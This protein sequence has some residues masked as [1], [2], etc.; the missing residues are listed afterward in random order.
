[1]TRPITPQTNLEN[2]KKEAK[3]WLKVLRAGD[4]E[5][6]ERFAQTYPKAPA[7]PGLRDVQ[8][9]LARVYGFENWKSLKQALEKRSVP[10]NEAPRSP[11]QL[12]ALFL[13]Y[14]CPD[15]HVRGRPAHHMAIHAAK[16]LLD[17][18]PEIARSNLYTAIVCGEIDEVE[19]I[20]R[21]QP[22]LVRMKS[23]DT[24]ADR[25]DV[26]GSGDLFKNIGAKGWE[27]LSYLCFARLD[28]SKT[29]DNA[30]AIARLLLDHGADPNVYFMAGDSRYTPLTGV[31]GEG[32]EDRP[33]HPRRDE[34]ARLLLE[35]GAEPYDGQVIYNIHFHGNVLWYLKLMYEFSLKAGRKADWDDPEWHMLDQGNYGSGARWHL[36][37]AIDHND[38][39]LAE[40]CL[41]HGATPNAATPQGRPRKQHPLY[42]Q[43]VRLG[44]TE[45]ATL[46]ERHGATRVTIATDDEDALLAACFRRDRANAER[47]LQA[48]PEYLQSHVA[49]HSAAQQDRADVVEFVL[50]LGVS[51]NVQDEGQG[52][53]TALHVAAYA[54]SESVVDML[55]RRGAKIDPVDSVH[56]ATPLWFAMWAQR[57]RIITL[58]ARYSRDVW[59]LNF[60]GH[61]E[62][63]REVLRAEPRFA[64]MSG[65][66]TPLF[67]LPED[68]QQSV[69]IVEMFLALG[70]D[71]RFRR[72]ED[73]LT[74]SDVAR[75]R[76]LDAAADRL[77]AAERHTPQHPPI[78]TS[79][80]V[81]NYERLAVAMVKAYADADPESL[82]QIRA[83]YGR[84]FTVDDLRAIVWR[85]MYK[86]RQASG[87]AEAF[88]LAEAQELIAR[89][90]GYPNWSELI[91][92]V[93]TGT[94]APGSVYAFDPKENRI[95]PRRILH[96]NEWDAIIAVMQERR[97][98]ALDAAGFVTDEA[99]ERIADLEFVTSLNL[100]GSRGLSDDGLRQ[101]ARMPQLE[102]LNLS[103]YPGGKLTDKGLEVLRHLPNLKR[104][105]MT[106]QKGISDAGPA[107]LKYCDQLESVNL[108]GTR[109]G[110][111][112]IEAL[113][114]KK[115][116]RHFSS[117]G[118]ATDE[119]LALLHDFP[120]F[121][122]WQ[123]DEPAD[124]SGS[125]AEPTKLLIDGPFTDRGLA[126]L[127]GLEGIF[128]LD[129]FWHVTGITTD[130]FASLAGMTHLGSLGCDG[131]L[132][133]DTSMRHIAA[134]PRL[135]RL[136]AQ[137]SIAGDDGFLALSA[138][139]TLE[140]FWGRECPNF[141][142]RG[143]VAFSR[144]PA[145]NT[146]GIGCG[147]VDDD[148][149]S[150]LPQFPSLRELTA[151]GFQDRG[152][153]HIGRCEKLQR[154]LCMY[155][156][157]TTDVATEHIAALHLKS[158]Y[159]GLTQITD[160]S[161]EVL[162]RMSTLEAV[163]LFETKNISD[164]GLGYLA[165]LPHLK[166]VELSGLPHVTLAGTRVFPA[167]VQ[168]NYDV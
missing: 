167:S 94:P 12:I 156:R 18:H 147:K 116:L 120:M 139:Q 80:E 44:E 53:Q 24:A 52:K 13:D 84:S 22:Q 63:V 16:R 126:S 143:F 23:G 90:S 153:R 43:A 130:G 164:A 144:M 57:T 5:A 145:L 56:D 37:V 107:N 104:F 3:R 165:K 4:A 34:L 115:K 74:A 86:V 141:G 58:L 136:R 28:L 91:E 138:S 19:R 7:A 65:E 50:D 41:S 15:H 81:A 27:P 48:H 162:G 102:N 108:M 159:A 45:I 82:K 71:A 154:L 33:P 122:T 32:E 62:R 76:G 168:V 92:S 151:I 59:A 67:W 96:G 114:G 6:R 31:I 121:K 87:S 39:E 109:T 129:L 161:L 42:E 163:E 30:V 142:S 61:V 166:R 17:K 98:T 75:R 46:F 131:K 99:L 119:G 113:G 123:V 26:G 150:T 51:M 47:I 128:A 89:T 140:R 100:G 64:T 155:C 132:A 49:L 36:Q 69:E 148:A 66:S 124:L 38:L 149:L 73:G 21:E 152:F 1:M 35:R 70:A 137:E 111:G 20:L 8:Y 40:W 85:L 134:I 78:H 11:E 118:L 83:R 133:D 14:A 106:W 77:A 105:E 97:I 9:A 55:V 157:D 10:D 29:N 117:G 101:L 79:P 93:E 2:L 160:R 110:D 60:T 112:V 103:E 54:G 88:G 158:Y 25:S 68:E 125:D 135:R 127:A 146:L 72:Q 95:S